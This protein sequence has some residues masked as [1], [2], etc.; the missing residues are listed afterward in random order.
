MGEE[1][2]KA[3]L[4]RQQFVMSLQEE[5]H[6]G[7]ILFVM[8][9]LQ[10]QE[11]MCYDLFRALTGEV[12]YGAFS[13]IL[14]SKELSKPI[15]TR[16][17][18]MSGVSVVQYE[19]LEFATCLATA[20]TI[21]TN[22]MLPSYYVRREEQAYVDIPGNNRER[23]VSQLLNTT[24]LLSKGPAY[25]KQVYEQQYRLRGIYTGIILEQGTKSLKEYVTEVIKVV[26]YHEIRQEK[27]LVSWG[28]C[29]KPKLLF[30]VD[31]EKE[32]ALALEQY[33]AILNQLIESDTEVTLLISEKETD[34]LKA[35]L[36]GLKKRIHIIWRTGG[37]NL[38]Q[39]EEDQL[40]RMREAFAESEQIEEVMELR[41]AAPFVLE[42]RRMLGDVV[43]DA[44]YLISPQSVFWYGMFLEVTSEA[45]FLIQGRRFKNKNNYRIGR[46][47]DRVIAMNLAAYQGMLESEELEERKVELFDTQYCLLRSNS[48]FLSVSISGKEY[49]ECSMLPYDA[50]VQRAIYVKA[51]DITKTS[52]FLSI[53]TLSKE[54]QEQAIEGCLAF[55]EEEEQA[56]IYMEGDNKNQIEDERLIMVPPEVVS[57]ELLERFDLLLSIT[58]GTDYKYC[59]IAALIKKPYGTV[60]LQGEVRAVIKEETK[61]L[62]ESRGM[63]CDGRKEARYR[64]YQKEEMQKLRY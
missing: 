32:E 19:S 25:T 27:G 36:A 3:V 29:G 48:H 63:Y 58:A 1:K 50:G 51:P 35:R 8:E 45:V 54:E 37:K 55:L 10:E 42:W 26:L 64:E 17:E 13:V 47:Y 33:K 2:E 57:V 11:T 5:I 43:F 23:L 61:S 49:L 14:C 56:E 34:V 21:M 31:V 39:K 18:Q 20:E 41:P 62:L 46:Y 60:A 15:Q 52:Y 59:Y 16:Y 30:V 38:G 53:V 9:Y 6:A 4:P 22:T 28:E 24:C 12:E 44:A 40:E 7:E